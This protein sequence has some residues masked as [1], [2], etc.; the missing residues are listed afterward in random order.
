MTLIESSTVYISIAVPTDALCG[1]IIL[2]A[3]ATHNS[4]GKLKFTIG[5]FHA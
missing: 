2:Y 4:L 1:T 3:I 5:N